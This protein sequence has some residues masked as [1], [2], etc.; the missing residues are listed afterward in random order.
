MKN[1]TCGDWIAERLKITPRQ[2]S[3]WVTNL[4]S[5]QISDDYKLLCLVVARLAEDPFFTISCVNY[6]TGSSK[7]N[8]PAL[9]YNPLEGKGHVCALHFLLSQL[10]K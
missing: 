10:S 9:D 6:A 8:L 5:A 2:W 3:L 1:E 4:N 7:P